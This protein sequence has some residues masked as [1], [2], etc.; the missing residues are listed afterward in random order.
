MNETT[1]PPADPSLPGARPGGRRER[2][3]RRARRRFVVAAVVVALG[4]AAL[5]A[6]TIASADRSSGGA[7]WSAGTAPAAEAGGA[8]FEASTFEAIADVQEFWAETLPAT[9]GMAYEP[10]PDDRLHPYTEDDPPPACDG[11]D[12]SAPYD[13]VAN[14]A[15]YCSLDDF[16]AW[17]DQQLIPRLRETYGDFAVALVMA[18]EWGHAV[19]ALAEPRLHATVLLE[20]QA[21]CFA[22]A[23]AGDVAARSSGDLAL[24]SADLDAALGGYLEFRDPVG[25]DARQSG[26]HGN[27]FDRVSAFQDGF[28][29]GADACADYESDPPSI[30]ETGFTSRDDA[31]NVGNL[32]LDEVLPLIVDDLQAYWS[33]EEPSPAPAVE[34]DEAAGGSCSGETDRGVL[35]PSVEFCAESNTITY[36][37]ELLLQVHEQIGDFSVGMMIAAAWSSSVQFDQ[38]AQLG[39]AAQHQQ[40]ECLAGAWTGSVANGEHSTELSL[41]PGDL[42]EAIRT[43]VAVGGRSGSDDT[44]F[45]RVETFRAGFVGGTDAC[46]DRS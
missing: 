34:E 11:T 4:A 2:R 45:V 15:F 37:R 1:A 28:R 6:P 19:Q 12:R 13:D 24:G 33:Q 20:L 14:N 10:I 9:Y 7:T 40:A 30:T 43:Y 36:D 17:D 46:S 23:W 5:A 21:D 35:D 25:T 42:D 41:S 31:A 8:R 16:V 39:T 44:A 38:G 29:N 22:G 3:R 26:A 32:P 27:A 18:H